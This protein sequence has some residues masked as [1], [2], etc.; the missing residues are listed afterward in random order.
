MEYAMKKKKEWYAA[1]AVRPIPL[2]P[3]TWLCASTVD[4][5]SMNMDYKNPFGD[6]E[7]DL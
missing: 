4:T 3:E 2:V 1:P 7:Y 6:S 5:G